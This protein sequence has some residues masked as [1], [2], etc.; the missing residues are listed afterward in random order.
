[1][2]LNFSQKKLP[3]F[4]NQAPR[5]LWRDIAAQ[6]PY[7]PVDQYDPIAEEIVNVALDDVLNGGVSVSQALAQAHRLIK[8]RARRR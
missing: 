2:M 4:G 7:I 1:M 6:I 5:I 3:F 8:R